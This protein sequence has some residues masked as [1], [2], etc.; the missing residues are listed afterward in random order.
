MINLL[1]FLPSGRWNNP[2]YDKLE[3][4]YYYLSLF[5]LFAFS[6]C[7]LDVPE[8]VFLV[9][10]LSSCIVEII[11]SRKCYVDVRELLLLSGMLL[12]YIIAEDGAY[13]SRSLIVLSFYEY[14][15]LFMMH[16]KVGYK[17][18][19]MQI[20]TVMASG[21]TIGSVLNS[22]NIVYNGVRTSDWSLFFSGRLLAATYH[23][24]FTLIPIALIFWAIISIREH[25]GLSLGI[26]AYGVV[27]NIIILSTG[28]RSTII[29]TALTFIVCGLMFFVRNLKDQ[30]VRKIYMCCIASWLGLML[31]L[32]VLIAVNAF[33]LK[34]IYHSDAIQYFIHRNGGVVGNVRFTE[35]KYIMR[36]MLKFPLGDNRSNYTGI[37]YAHNVWVDMVRVSGIIPF[38]IIC[39][40]SI[41]SVGDVLKLHVITRRSDKTYYSYFFLGLL[42]SFYIYF[43]TEPALDISVLFWALSCM[44][45]GAIRASTIMEESNET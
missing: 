45:S 6:V 5:V 44:I 30:K 13:L 40:Y 34:D 15:K 25:I 31:V 3:K 11:L 1:S 2:I 43:M 38:A 7:F 35:Q 17:K 26:I 36:D 16:T 32:I 8:T 29:I 42:F 10:M 37:G 12:Y 9:W 21:M 19:G 18:R 41:M 20:F 4:V 22:T 14:A 27:S 23:V 28:T 24:F 39:I 33:G